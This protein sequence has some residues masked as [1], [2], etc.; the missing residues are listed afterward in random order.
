MKLISP[1]VTTLN[2][3]WDVTVIFKRRPV[4]SSNSAAVRPKKLGGSH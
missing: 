2:F 4:I 1:A 3:F